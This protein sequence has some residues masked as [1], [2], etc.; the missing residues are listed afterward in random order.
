MFV[1]HDYLIYYMHF[2]FDYRQTLCLF[3]MKYD[4]SYTY[5][6]NASRSITY[7]VKYIDTIRQTLV[8]LESD[9]SYCCVFRKHNR[10]RTSHSSFIQYTT[11]LFN[12]VRIL[13]YNDPSNFILRLDRRFSYITSCKVHQK[14]LQ[15]Y[16]ST[17]L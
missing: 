2:R 5:S 15:R 7:L 6:I 8:S 3:I 10:S 17:I 14:D 11:T 1:S 4:Y 12:F 13:L 9:Q 16:I